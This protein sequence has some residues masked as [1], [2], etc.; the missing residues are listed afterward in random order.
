MAGV[1]LAAAPSI[2]GAL[3]LGDIEV[4]SALGQPLDARV[5]ILTQPGDR[6]E[7]ACFYISNVAALPAGVQ[8]AM[9]LERS[10][11]GAALRIRSDVPVEVPASAIQLA[12]ACPGREADGGREYAVLLD[13]PGQIR[14]PSVSVTVAAT[15]LAR[16][17]DSLASIARKV[18]PQDANARALYLQALVDAN[19]ALAAAG[20]PQTIVAGAAV[21][22]PDLRDFA[23]GRKPRAAAP[24]RIAA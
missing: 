24:T 3:A 20:D 17:D 13:P 19:P 11:R 7:A 14:A 6:F 18:F 2:A 8:L 5:P 22:L 10:A 16:P 23:T 15:V 21:A 9:T 4:R 12:I 1:V